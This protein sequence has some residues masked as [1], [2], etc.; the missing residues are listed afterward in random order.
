[1]VPMFRRAPPEHGGSQPVGPA[2]GLF[3]KDIKT[4][5]DLFVDCR[6]GNLS[7]D[8]LHGVFLHGQ[9]RTQHSPFDLARSICA[10]RKR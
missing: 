3:T 10:K 9:R 6:A 1:M 7:R 5:N 4:M 8:V 2:M